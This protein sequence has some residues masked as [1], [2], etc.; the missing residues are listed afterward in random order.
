MANYVAIFS[1]KKKSCK[2]KIY[3]SKKESKLTEKLDGFIEKIEPIVKWGPPEGSWFDKF[4]YWILCIGYFIASILLEIVKF[5][6]ALITIDIT[7]G[8]IIFKAA[9]ESGLNIEPLLDKIPFLR[10]WLEGKVAS[11]P[12]FQLPHHEALR[13][14]F[15]YSILGVFAIWGLY[16][17]LKFVLNLLISIVSK[18]RITEEVKQKII[19]FIKAIYN[20]FKLVQRLFSYA[21]LCIALATA[22]IKT[23]YCFE[24]TISYVIEMLISY[25]ILLVVC[26]FCR[27]EKA[28]IAFAYSAVASKDS[29]FQTHLDHERNNTSPCQNETALKD[30]VSGT[31]Q[32]AKQLYREI[33]KYSFILSVVTILFAIGFSLLGIDV[34]IGVSAALTLPSLLA[35]CIG[36]YVAAKET[37]LKDR[38]DSLS[39]H[40]SK[41]HNH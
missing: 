31:Q 20:F 11:L 41:I 26:A 28:I 5:S 10:I 14:I 7:L 13:T 15:G 27:P 19:K 16:V 21:C 34:V 37:Y 6:S 17:I 25:A 39:S 24:F 22:I 18:A 4:K 40:Q 29:N 23:F 2:T 35:R 1:P 12:V 38:F 9:K 8:D 30:H 33:L 3:N 36:R 32:Y